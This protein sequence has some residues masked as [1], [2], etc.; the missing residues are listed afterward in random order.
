MSIYD[1]EAPTGVFVNLKKLPN[2]TAH[3]RLFGDPIMYEKETEFN[4]KKDRATKFATLC[5]FR[6]Q[7]TK[8]SEV[9][10]FEFG[11][12]VQKQLRQLFQDADWGDPN[13]AE[14]DVT[15]KREGE[16]LQTEYFVTPRPKKPL[17]DE[18]KALTT[19]H[20]IDL[21]KT[22]KADQPTSQQE[23]GYDPFADQ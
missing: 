15:I 22:V 23:D 1:Q 6:N 18:E 3:L 19:G 20:G 13:K 17:T 7:T 14:Y 5:L 4:G 9:K 8:E 16:G 2:G 21:R 10:V 11:W 12:A